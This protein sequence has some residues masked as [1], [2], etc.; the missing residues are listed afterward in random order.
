M[1]YLLTLIICSGVAGECQPVRGYPV[2]KQ[3]Y[4]T[5][6]LDGLIESHKFVTKSF[7]YD[8]LEKFKVIP[9]YT[10][11]PMQET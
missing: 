9:K 8:Q 7:T 1:K 5:C 11:T 3:D 2:P 6:I 4:P 10:C